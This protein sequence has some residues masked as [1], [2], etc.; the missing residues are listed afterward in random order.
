[1]KNGRVWRTI[2][3][4]MYPALSVALVL[5]IWI[6]MTKS[7]LVPE[8]ILP[9]PAKVLDALREEINDGRLAANLSASGS[10]LIVGYLIGAVTGA[11]L[12][13][14][15]GMVWVVRS[16]LFPLVEILRPIPPLAWVPLALIWFGIGE[17]SKIFL[18]ALTVCF[19]VLIATMN[20][21]RQIDTVLL[22]AAQSMDTPST[23]TLFRVV[24]PA[25]IP[26]LLTGL[27][28]GW[29]LG[30]TIL[31]G[32]EMIAASSGIGYLIINGMNIGRF[33]QVI[34]GILIL[35][36]F[37]VVTDACFVGLRRT[38]VLRWHAGSDKVVG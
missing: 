30:I 35:G 28:L 19:P 15:L 7:G 4:T 3:G 25:A 24:L 29:T 1:M 10:R 21:V 11:L 5:L 34:L 33:D 22:R 38:K 17:N 12:G 20:G 26:D 23:T 27:R 32:A 18:I 37:G 9:S 6:S 13:L 16:A 36:T 14:V 2:E 31:V 8:S